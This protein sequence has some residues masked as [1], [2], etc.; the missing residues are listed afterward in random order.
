MSAVNQALSRRGM[1]A[2]TPALDQMSSGAPIAVPN[3]TPTP[4]MPPMP[5]ASGAMPTPQITQG[6]DNEQLVLKALTTWL[7]NEAKRK[8]AQV[9]PI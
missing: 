8:Q 7:N 9:L 1:G 2:P 3:P 4:P 6:G 5:S